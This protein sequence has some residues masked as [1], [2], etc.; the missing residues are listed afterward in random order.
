M[1]TCPSSYSSQPLCC[2]I[3]VL[4]SALLRP[5][6]FDRKIFVPAPDIK[7]RA[8][9]FK[10]HLRNLKTSLDKDALARKLAA[11]TPGFSG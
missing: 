4:D 2:R 5:S 8:S 9:I 6:R 3:D 11:S 10:V 1:L 7:G